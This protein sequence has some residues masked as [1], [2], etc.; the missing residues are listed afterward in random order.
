MNNGRD[1]NGGCTKTAPAFSAEWQIL[2][3]EWQNGHRVFTG[4]SK[5]FCVF[6]LVFDFKCLV[7]QN[8]L[9]IEPLTYTLRAKDLKLTGS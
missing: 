3:C 5:I 7:L 8:N 4:R 9:N 6:I 1:K 2:G